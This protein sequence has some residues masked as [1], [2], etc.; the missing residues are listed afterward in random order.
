MERGQEEDNMEL[1]EDKYVEQHQL[2]KYSE[3]TIAVN[4]DAEEGHPSHQEEEHPSHQ[5]ASKKVSFGNVDVRVKLPSF[6][7]TL[8]R[9]EIEK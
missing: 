1:C 5:V 4:K 2:G 6:D 8:D 9:D 7:S 3:V